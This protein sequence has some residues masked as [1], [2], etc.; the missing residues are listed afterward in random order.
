ML[1]VAQAKMRGV[2]RL[3]VLALALQVAAPA[4]PSAMSLADGGLQADL[5]ASLCHSSS[6]ADSGSPVRTAAKH[7]IFCLPL[8]AA[9]VPSGEI[10]LSVPMAQTVVIMAVTVDQLPQPQRHAIAHPRAPPVIVRAS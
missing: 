10:D 7:C 2:G 1:S 5:A 9:P 4:L 3:L 8:I 6:D